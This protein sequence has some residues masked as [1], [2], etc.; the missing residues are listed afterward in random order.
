[1]IDSGERKSGERKS[2]KSGSRSANRGQ[3]SVKIKTVTDSKPK[4]R[5]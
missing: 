2:A 3:K 4:S 5:E 1:M